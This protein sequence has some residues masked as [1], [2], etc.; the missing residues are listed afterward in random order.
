MYKETGIAHRE[1]NLNPKIVAPFRGNI[2]FPS[3]LSV[4]FYHDCIIRGKKRKTMKGT[5]LCCK[6]L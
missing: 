5:N 3:L 4:V 1:R 6:K 2:D